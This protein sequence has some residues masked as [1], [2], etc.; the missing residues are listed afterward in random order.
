MGLNSYNRSM[1]TIMTTLLIPGVS[2]ALGALSKGKACHVLAAVSGGA[3]S[4]ALLYALKELRAC[5]GFFLSCVHV[6]HGLRGEESLADAAFVRN[7]CQRWSIP[8]YEEKAQGLE[9]HMNGLEAAAR[10][11]RYAAFQKVYDALQA[12]C[13]MLAHHQGD[14]AETLIMRLMRGAGVKGLGGIVADTQRQG[15]RILRP[16]LT[17]PPELL[18]KALTEVCQ[19]WREDASNQ[20]PNNWRNALRLQVIPQLEALAPG[21]QQRMSRTAQSLQEVSDFLNASCQPLLEM[22]G[23]MPV[24]SWKESHP[25]VQKQ[26]LRLWA[27]MP[28]DCDQ[29]LALCR[30]MDQPAGSVE[31]LPGGYQ[32]YRGYRYLH[33]LPA[34]GADYLPLIAQSPFEGL[35]GDGKTAQ[36]LPLRLAEKARW[37]TRQPGDVIRP[38]GMNGAQSLQDYLT[39]RKVDQPFRDVMPLLALDHEILWVPGVGASQSCRLTRDEEACYYYLRS[40]LPWQLTK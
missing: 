32:A 18:R 13:L 27:Q 34:S 1:L 35:M 28:L 15:M 3:D 5:D 10:Q 14:Q 4:T 11:A 8:F 37:R 25:A 2:Q 33:R 21:C 16:F 19:P 31:N 40:P 22:P 39:N 29:T 17:F 6:E 36:A 26:A 38:F 12:D 30:L 7:L 9:P 20:V 24:A 23:L